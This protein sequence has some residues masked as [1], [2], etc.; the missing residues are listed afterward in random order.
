MIIAIDPGI[1]GGIAYYDP[2][3]NY[4]RVDR[5]PVQWRLVN[6]KKR[7]EID[8]KELFNRLKDC[9]VVIHTVICEEPHAMPGAGAASQFSFGSTCGAIRAILA[10]LST[11]R[12]IDKV[13][14]VDPSAWKTAMKCPSDKHRARQLAKETFPDYAASFNATSSDGMAE[15]ALMAWYAANTAVIKQKERTAVKRKGRA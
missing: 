11:I 1:T 14:Y 8:V 13:L 4:L 9:P 2:E 3:L 12:H 5:L 6:G 7:N 10:C 15:A